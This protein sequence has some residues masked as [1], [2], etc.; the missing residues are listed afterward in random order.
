MRTHGLLC[1][2]LLAVAA[3]AGD[4]MNT[5]SRQDD[6]RRDYAGGMLCTADPCTVKITVAAG[7]TATVD[8][9]TLGVDRTLSEV[10]VK[11]E[12]QAQSAGRVVFVAAPADGINPKPPPGPWNA[13]FKRPNRAS[14]TVFTWLDKNKLNGGQLRRR[15]DYNI[16]MTQD[17]T[18][19]HVDPII[20]N[21]Y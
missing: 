7:C 6:F 19:C 13:E 12:I 17:G 9:P 10:T 8:P 14:D 20:I 1:L 5:S 21:D 18:A 3:C 2:A 4:R 16:D 15:H 11:W